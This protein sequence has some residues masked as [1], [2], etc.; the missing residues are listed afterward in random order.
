MKRKHLGPILF[1]L[2]LAGGLVALL[3]MLWGLS[4]FKTGGNILA[5]LGEPPVVE[6]AQPADGTL[7]ASGRGVIVAAVA[8]SDAGLARVDFLADGVVTQQYILDAPG[9]QA[10][11]AAFPWF[12]SQTG[13]HELSV[14]AYDINGR[15]S[16]AAVVR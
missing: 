6:I 14:V 1:I 2:I 7:I 12:G 4:T 15:A 13:W 9:E 11:V 16:D 3:L 5:S 8:Q 10:A